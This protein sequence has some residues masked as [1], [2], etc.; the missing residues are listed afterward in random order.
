MDRIILFHQSKLQGMLMVRVRD[1]RH[2]HYV[3]LA[4]SRSQSL[5]APDED[6]AH[7]MS[8]FWPNFTVSMEVVCPLKLCVVTRYRI[9]RILWSARMTSNFLSWERVGVTRNLT[10]TLA[11]ELSICSDSDRRRR[12]KKKPHLNVHQR[13][14]TQCCAKSAFNSP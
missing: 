3:L 1:R 10:E 8:S 5:R 7:R 4:G 6:P 14:M 9:E 12:R 13:K 2:E 11:H